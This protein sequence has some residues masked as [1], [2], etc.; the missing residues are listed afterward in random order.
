[1]RKRISRLL[2]LSVIAGL[3][4]FAGCESDNV[5]PL[6]S[7]SDPVVQ[8]VPLPKPHVN[9]QQVLWPPLPQNGQEVDLA[10]DLL[11]DNVYFVLDASGSMRYT[12][13]G[14]NELG[15]SR[16]DI[17]KRAIVEVFSTLPKDTNLGL[18]IFDL[19]GTR[20]RVP[21]GNGPE[22]RDKFM[23]AINGAT[24]DG[25][26]PLF[27]AMKNAYSKITVQ[28]QRQLGYGP[29]RIVVVTDGRAEPDSQD[30]RPIVD[31]IFKESPVEMITIGFCIG[32]S[33]ALNQPG[34]TTYFEANDYTSL[35][36]A[37]RHVLAESSGYKDTTN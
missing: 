7:A 32:S 11:A 10:D 4:V 5:S 33:H 20:E 30:P 9:V 2:S 3:L 12:T 29:Y 18:Q 26:T 15:G 14:S 13:C 17:A 35:R 28:G 31:R 34:K 36:N 25:G 22:N 21:L 19:S 6:S 24:A 1:M 23:R 27:D 16:I 8:N 37:L